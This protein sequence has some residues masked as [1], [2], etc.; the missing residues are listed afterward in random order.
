M[1][2][3]ISAE[4]KAKV[5]LEAIKGQKTIN[6]LASIE[7]QPAQKS[8][9]KGYKETQSIGNKDLDDKNRRFGTFSTFHLA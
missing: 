2:K 3:T 8:A 6:E 9:R 7:V 5:A 1:R 4:L